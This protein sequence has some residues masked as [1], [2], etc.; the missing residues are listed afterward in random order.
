MLG[1]IIHW[2]LAEHWS[3]ACDGWLAKYSQW[4]TC[5]NGECTKLNHARVRANDIDN[6]TN[7]STWIFYSMPSGM[8]TGD[9]RFVQMNFPNAII[10]ELKLDLFKYCHL[11]VE[12]QWWHDWHQLR[13]VTL[14]M[15]SKPCQISWNES[16]SRE[17]A[18]PHFQTCPAHKTLLGNSVGMK[19]RLASQ[20]YT[21]AGRHAH[22][23]MG[24]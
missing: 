12:L 15:E 9:R 18:H 1:N 13:I 19:P 7:A 21:T 23:I 3:K 24:R 10:C 2:T 16:Y 4:R 5:A 6:M 8:R 11:M 20:H 22:L 17:Y 14:A